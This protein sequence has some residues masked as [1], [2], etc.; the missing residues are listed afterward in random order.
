MI[1]KALYDYYHRS[2]ELARPGMEYKEIAFPIVS[3]S[4]LIEI[5]SSVSRD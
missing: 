2:K 5:I 3:Y 4:E 1:L